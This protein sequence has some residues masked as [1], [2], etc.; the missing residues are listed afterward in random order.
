[1]EQDAEDHLTET[2]A[3]SA[4]AANPPGE[5]PPTEYSRTPSLLDDYDSTFPSLLTKSSPK[6]KEVLSTDHDGRRP[7]CLGGSLPF[8]SRHIQPQHLPE[9]VPQ[10]LREYHQGLQFA[11]SSKQ[12]KENSL[13]EAV[14]NPESRQQSSNQWG[15]IQWAKT[16]AHVVA[17]AQTSPISDMTLSVLRSTSAA[18]QSLGARSEQ[19][20]RKNSVDIDVA[21]ED[22]SV[23]HKV[24]MTSRAA[25]QDQDGWNMVEATEDGYD[26]VDVE[27]AGNM[28][29]QAANPE[30]RDNHEGVEWDLCG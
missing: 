29:A 30:H 17:P 4:R 1:K 15:R 10:N 18:I 25:H 27:E 28:L 13:M 8:G 3:A 23:L 24:A 22:S 26:A 12:Q 20:Q 2:M 14:T 21:I 6:G 7:G 5:M 11:E 9:D 19:S 16:H